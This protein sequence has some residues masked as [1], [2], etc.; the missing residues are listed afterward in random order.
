MSLVKDDNAVSEK[1][2]V[3]LKEVCVE[4]IVV[5]HEEQSG[6]V[7][8]V[9]GVEVR[10]KLL[11]KANRLHFWDIDESVSE[12]FLADPYHL[13]LFFVKLASHVH[14]LRVDLKIGISCHLI[15]YLPE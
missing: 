8:D 14:R 10:A 12:P 1:F 2:Q 3:G 5:R 4:E 13:F 6:D 11:L 7:L 9:V 15:F